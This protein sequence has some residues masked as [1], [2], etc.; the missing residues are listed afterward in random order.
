MEQKSN[1]LISDA[2]EIIGETVKKAE[3]QNKDL[4]LKKKEK[5]KEDEGE[6]ETVSEDG[7][8]AE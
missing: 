4:S 8:A 5:D 6:E 7:Q 2:G 1:E 3:E